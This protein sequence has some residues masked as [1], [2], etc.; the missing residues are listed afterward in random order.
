[1]KSVIILRG[2]S[3]KLAFQYDQSEPKHPKTLFDSP[4]YTQ[5]STLIPICH[6][7]VIWSQQPPDRKFPPLDPYTSRFLYSLKRHHPTIRT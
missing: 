2:K 4:E 5:G 6:I 3:A 7:I 1:M